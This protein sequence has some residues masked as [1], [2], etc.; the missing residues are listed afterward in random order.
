MGRRTLKKKQLFVVA[1]MH[2]SGTSAFARLLTVFDVALGENLRPPADDNP[3]GFWEDAA[4][5]AINERLLTEIGRDWYSLDGYFLS[6]EFFA[7]PRFDTLRAD[8]KAL[9]E[10][11]LNDYPR[12]GVKD[13]RICRLLGFWKSMFVTLGIEVIYLMAIRD[14]WD[15]AASLSARDGFGPR[16]G[17]ALWLLHNLDLVV[18]LAGERAHLASYDA[19]L[20]D[21]YAELSNLTDLLAA[22][23]QPDETSVSAFVDDYLDPGLRHRKHRREA[24]RLG[25]AD[26]FFALLEAAITDGGRLSPSLE[27]SSRAFLARWRFDATLSLPAEDETRL[28]QEMDRA[29]LNRNAEREHL[30]KEFVGEESRL[31][32]NL[33]DLQRSVEFHREREDKLKAGAREFEQQSADT[34]A[35]LQREIVATRRGFEANEKR[36]A[37]TVAGLQQEIIESRQRHEAAEQQREETIATLQD[38][39]VDARQALVESQGEVDA[40]RHQLDATVV[41]LSERDRELEAVYTSRSWRFSGPLRSSAAALRQ[42]RA[43]LGPRTLARTTWRA[44]VY[45]LPEDSRVRARLLAFRERVRTI[46]MG[47]SHPMTFAGGHAATIAYRQNDVVAREPNIAADALPELDISVVTYNSARWV[48]TFVASLLAQDYPLAKLNL[49]IVDNDST[50]DTVARFESLGE[51]LTALAGFQVVSAPNNG[52]GAGHNIGVGAGAA[53]F[54]LVTNV[55]LEYET[56]AI[57]NLVAHA[58]ID[59]ASVGSWECRQLP[60]EHPKFYDPVALETSWSAH[61]CILFRRSCFA[62]AGGYEERIF[63]YGEDVELSFRLRSLGYRLRY[64]PS[65]VVW[66][67]TYDEPGE[68]KPL[69]FEGSTL[70]NGYMRMRYG[71]FG[72]AL[73]IIP[74]F[75]ALLR[76]RWRVADQRRQVLRNIGKLIRHA[77]YFLSKRRSTQAVFPFRCWDYELTRDG[78]FFV[79]PEQSSGDIPLVSVV[80]RTYRGRGR[81]LR[82]ALQSAVNQTWRAIEV[83]VVEDGGATLEPL[84]REFAEANPGRSIRFVEMPRVG[85]CEAGN[86]GLAAATGEYLMFLDDDDLLFCDHIETCVRQLQADAALGGVYAL[87]WEVPTRIDSSLPAGYVEEAHLTAD[88]VRYEFDREVL[89]AHNYIAIQSVVFRRELF[90]RYGGFDLELENL[91]DWNLWFRYTRRHDFKLVAKTTSMYRTPAAVGDREKR[92]QVLDS[93]YEAARDKNRAFVAELMPLEPPVS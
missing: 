6:E 45:R 89:A 60:Y 91:E 61:A 15:V 86:A 41:T 79:L 93:Y 4:F 87:P 82:E 57:T 49:T 72:D 62:R 39:V 52:F 67:Y 71:S 63:M 64:I 40:V 26:E 3:R 75:G 38:E 29:L 1:G 42:L 69:Q 65:S 81:L 44:S 85:R 51:T 24:D 84:V 56:D 34:V 37:T 27:T 30:L 28:R 11:R 50:D 17:Q 58:L 43:R 55:D 47:T 13:P 8:A 90:D 54:V 46:M 59:D 88:V 19:L 35:T 53:E 21:P 92:Q 78:A 10:E 76:D 25:V 77:P 32:K 74:M 73:A 70:S 83:V 16:H 66:H 5:V 68:D 48:E 20:A 12:W 14:P 18:A 33:D 9:L 80:T 22:D 36:S 31:R 7:A 23:D 2:R